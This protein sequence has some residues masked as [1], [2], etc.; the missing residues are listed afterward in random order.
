[1]ATYYNGVK[2]DDYG[3]VGDQEVAWA[4][5]AASTK[6]SDG[7]DG[8]VLVGRRRRETQI[9]FSL[10]LS[11]NQA[12]CVAAVNELAKLFADEQSTG[13]LSLPG[14]D[15]Q[16]EFYYAYPSFTLKPSNYIDGMVVPMAFT[17]PDG[18]AV[19]AV[20]TVELKPAT[21]VKV[22]LGGSY[23]PEWRCVVSTKSTGG[24]FA[25]QFAKTADMADLQQ[26][27]FIITDYWSGTA[28]VDSKLRSCYVT[29]N[30]GSET[31]RFYTVPPLTAAWPVLK[32]GDVYVR[33]QGTYVTGATI[34]FEELR[35][36]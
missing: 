14:Q 7:M 22:E 29:D 33:V 4:D 28:E 16:S 3:V 13:K 25:I 12:E 2:L 17:V 11:G 31:R 30:S 10:A 35:A 15:E 9:K 6:S 5:F 34:D 1:M 23:E 24:D 36:C 26:V 21:A 32:P 8:S 27:D 19:R 20:D 18:C